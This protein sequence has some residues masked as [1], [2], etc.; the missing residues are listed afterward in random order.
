[1]GTIRKRKSGSYEAIYR[2]PAGRTRSRSLKTKAQARS[3][4]STVETEKQRGTWTDPQFARTRFEEWAEEFWRTKLNRRRSTKMRDD[5]YIRNHVLPTFG[6]APLGAITQPDV[7]AWV[8]K[9]AKKGLAANTVKQCYRLMAATMAAAVDARLIPESPCRNISLPRPTNTE[10][11][12]LTAEEVQRLAEAIADPFRALVLSAAYL[13]C[14]WGELAGLKRTRLNLLHA[15]V[16]IVGSLEE[17]GGAAPKYVEAT[18]TI[19]S[20]RRVSMPQFLVDE[21]QDHL[22]KAPRSEFVFSTVEGHPLRRNNFRRRYWL[23]AVEEAGLTPLR[24]HDLRHTCASL[25]IAQGTHA[26]E[27]QVRLGH[28]SIAT[29]MNVYGH[30]LPSLDGRLNEGLERAFREA[31]RGEAGL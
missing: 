8:E 20:R 19:S 5:S 6:R 11:R 10:Q 17:V 26:K 30:L 31:E 24:F 2:D 29:T 14:R 1:M 23:P 4:L 15:T 12:F 25:L 27:I 13:G 9:L 22:S 7:R 18:K 21:L 3:F 28:A 16:E